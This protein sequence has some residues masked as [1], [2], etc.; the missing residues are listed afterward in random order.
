M[1]ELAR[2]WRLPLVAAAVAAAL[3]ALGLPVFAT[4]EPAGAAGTSPGPTRTAQDKI[5][6][7]RVG[8]AYEKVQRGQALTADERAELIRAFQALRRAGPMI[9]GQDERPGAAAPTPADRTG[10]VPLDQMTDK[11]T[12]KGED[13]GLYGGGKNVPPPQHQKAAQRE[14][15]R[16]VPLGPD[17]KPAPDG[18]VVLISIGMSNTTQEFSRFKELADR[19]DQKWSQLVIVDGAQGGQDAERWS[20]P[21]MPAWEVLRQRLE[22]AGVTAKQVQVAWV[23][24]A[25]MGPARFG[26]YPK[27][28]EE[29]IGHIRRSLQIARRKLPNLRVAYLSSR[30][31]AGY[32]TT[33]LN[34]EA[35]AYESALAVRRLILDQIK[36]DAALNYDAAKGEV[37]AP[38]LLWGPYLWAD[39]LTPRDSDGL[40]WKREDLARDGTHPSGTSGRDKVGRLLLGFCRTDP[41]AKC[42][43]KAPGAAAP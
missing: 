39:G 1:K 11:D 32:A 9:R 37:T 16:I 25:R 14:L 30:I 19:D 33:P 27:H 26:E 22:R 41:N 15:A 36:G 6:W 20:R 8:Q 10:L 24:H 34:P 38:L 21:E 40:V 18:K 3:W 31:Y 42:W 28:A 5:D 7:N 43:F 23:K 12:Y 29:L 17:G 35:Y 13:S 2:P 4:G